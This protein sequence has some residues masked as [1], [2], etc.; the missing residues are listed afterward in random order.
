MS[1]GW[2]IAYMR[3]RF[4]LGQTASFQ[5][6]EEVQERV[7]A[8][9]AP[10]L[11]YEVNHRPEVWRDFEDRLHQLSVWITV[12]KTRLTGSREQAILN[13]M[14]SA[15]AR[16]EAAAIPTPGRLPIDEIVRIRSANADLIDRGLRLAYAYRETLHSDAVHAQSSMIRL[17]VV[18]LIAQLIGMVLSGVA[19]W[20][21]YREMVAPLRAELVESQALVARNEKLAALGVLAAGVAHEIRNPLT[22][23]K[24]RLFTQQKGLSP[25][26]RERT[27]AEFIGR[28]IDRL[29]RIVSEFLRFARP[30]EPQLS[31]VS[32]GDLLRDV[33][34]LLGPRLR[35]S[36]IDLVIERTT[37]TRIALD[38]EQMK[39]VL[40]NLINNAADALGNRGSIKL[41]AMEEC[42]ALK[43]KTQSVVVLEVEDNGPGIE[44]DVQK[45]LFDPF[46]ST[47]ANGTG[48]GL[49][50]AAR[51][52]E[53]HRGV[54]RFQSAVGRGSTFRVVVPLEA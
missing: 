17:Q 41:R 26:S 42:L 34:E 32:P 51:I 49:A 39:Q 9:D 46:F 10:L 18:I 50:I 45:R 20:I 37:D 6:A 35:E 11:D 38:A 13:E 15:E 12:E 1:T 23:I 36:S 48:L 52:V 8:L 47:K 4:A 16:L 29:E 44:P 2:G 22:A 27:D 33:R 31:P 25:G 19:A 30:V 3:Q 14:Q 5:I 40:I 24:A 53:K 54:L 43:G 7:H 28:E 21:T